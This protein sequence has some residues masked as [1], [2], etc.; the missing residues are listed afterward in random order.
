MI[1][2]YPR[3]VV[4]VPVLVICCAFLWGCAGLNDYQVSG[5]MK[6]A[7]LTASVTVRRDEKG[8][9]YIHARNMDDA[10]MAHG[11]VTAQDRLFQME[12]TRRVAQG[13]LS[14]FAGEKTRELD[15][16]MRTIGFFRS[17]QRHAAILAPEPRR[18]LQRYV[19]GVNAY[20]DT[21]KETYHLEFKLVGIEPEK[22]T[23]ADSLALAYLLSWNSAANLKTEITAQM[24]VDAIGYEKAGTL[25][26]LNLNPDD[27]VDRVRDE[28]PGSVLQKQAGIASDPR[29]GAYL[30]G[31]PLKIGS[32]SWAVSPRFSH[33]GKPILANDPHLDA[34]ILPGPWYPCALITPDLRLVGAGFPGLGGMMV[35]RNDHVAVGITNAYGDAQDLYVETIDPENPDHYLEGAASIPFQVLEEKL[36]IKDKEAPGDMRAENVQIRLTA[37]GP[38][39]SDVFAELKTDKVF[40]LRWAPFETIQPEIGLNRM[41]H[42]GSAAEI[43]AA[44]K[45]LNIVMLNYV[46]ADTGGNIGWQT[47]GKLPIRRHKDGTLPYGVSGDD[48]NWKG[49]IPFEAMPH[50]NNP[51]KGWIGTCNHY[52]P[53]GDYPFYYSSYAAPSFRYRRLKQLLG[54]PGVKTPEDHW[55]YQRDTLN[56][57]AKTVAPMM[58]AALKKHPETAEMGRILSAWNFRDNADQAAPAIFQATYRRFALMT[59]QDELGQNLARAMLGNWYFWQ[60]RLV[61]MVQE[62]DSIWF[63]D[64]ATK[65]VT[66]TRDDLFYQAAANAAKALSA[67]MGS[68]PEN[69]R[70]GK[71]HTIEHV[72]PIRRE[73]IGKGWLGSGKLPASGSPQ[74]LL[75]NLYDFN[76]PF[77]VVISDSM[78]MVVDLG[79]PDKV[80]AVLPGGV[81]GRLFHPH[82]KDQIRP[83]MS[84]EKVYWWFSDDAIEAHTRHTLRLNP[85]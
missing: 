2:A 84:G 42:A 59:F 45:D 74:T 18:L 9:A 33:S 73:G 17:A 85:F 48:D 50:E 65:H 76:Q 32:N 34:R 49:W 22:W 1:S 35:F 77:E 70:W 29:L 20:I 41:L 64:I 63:D 66:E 71:I 61:K 43:R 7:G 60:E 14:E 79:D 72:S 13:R 69:W 58:A 44:L 6:L 11:F 80:L 5:Q 38:V 67:E 68:S 53:R 36:F 31:G 8:M 25:F 55:Q 12:L 37:R 15:M 78:R 47:T 4:V 39:L 81:C 10:V 54:R 52:T 62:N 30:S 27:P 56:I 16:R 57:M 83:F 21:R 75:R 3:T 26:P 24:L 40:S 46:Y 19:D 23:I 82:T 28:Y 51:E